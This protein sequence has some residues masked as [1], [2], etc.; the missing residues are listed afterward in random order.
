MADAKFS[1]ILESVAKNPVVK[2]EEY[3][4]QG[5]KVFGFT[6]SYVPE[7]LLYALG[8]VPVRLLGRAQNIQAA[9]RHFQSYCCSQ[10]RSLMEDFINK[11]YDSLDGVIFA[12]TCDT[13]QQFHDIMKRN[14]P[15]KF[16]RN[17]NLPSRLEGDVPF[18]YAV[19]ETKR[20]F[21]AIEEYV[22]IK[23]E[24][25]KLAESVKLYNAN[26]AL[27]DRI[28]ELHLKYP[29]K[30]PSRALLQAVLISQLLDKREANEALAPFVNSFDAAALEDTKRKRIMLIGSININEEVYDLADE[31]GATIADD[32][33]CTGRRYFEVAVRE[34]TIEGVVRRYMGRP[35]CAA[36]HFSQTSRIDYITG[37]AEKRHAAGAIFLYLKFCDPHSFDYP[38]IRNALEKKGVRTQLIEIEQVSGP[39]GQ[40]RTKIQAFVEMIS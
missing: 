33:M 17:L 29:E 9:D 18:R 30:I 21:S 35:H 1:E 40:L 2:I 32:D 12:H 26:R 20:V 4:K 39:S 14:F 25:Q 36:K 6:C 8:V 13:M 27:L 28:Y 22:G 3:K 15:D 34:P 23:L 38:D 19:A 7:E 11:T 16:I 10:V 5:R 37:L 24:P 31:F